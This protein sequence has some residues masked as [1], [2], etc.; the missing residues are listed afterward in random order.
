MQI[1]SKNAGGECE[2]PP[3]LKL[4]AFTSLAFAAKQRGVSIDTLKRD[5]DRRAARG[6]QRRIVKLS[7]RRYGMR[8]KHVLELE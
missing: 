5:D 6:E 8:L 3:T 2:L 7:E 1:K 4:E